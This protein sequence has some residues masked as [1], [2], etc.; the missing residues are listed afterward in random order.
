MSVA[1]TTN[2]M[3]KYAICNAVLC[4]DINLNFQEKDIIIVIITYLL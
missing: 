2:K 1:V 4:L 3:E